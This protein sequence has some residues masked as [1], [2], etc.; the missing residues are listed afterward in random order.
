MVIEE[1]FEQLKKHYRNLTK[2]K[3]CNDYLGKSESYFY[4]MRQLGK[5]ACND[6]LLKC[7]VGLKGAANR[8]AALGPTSSTYQTNKLLA[9]MLLEQIENKIGEEM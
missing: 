1:V 6:A 4:V 9:D 7:Y 3:F 5:V 8:M 2:K